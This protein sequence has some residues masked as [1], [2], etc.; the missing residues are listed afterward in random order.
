MKF[1]G[2]SHVFSIGIRSVEAGHFSIRQDLQVQDERES[3]MLKYLG[4]T[5]LLMATIWLPAADSPELVIRG[6]TKL[7]LAGAERVLLAARGRAAAL[8]VAENIAEVDSRQ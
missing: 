8:S 3:I 7:T 2:R 4:F 1:S 5:V 6:Q